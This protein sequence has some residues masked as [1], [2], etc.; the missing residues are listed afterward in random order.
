MNAQDLADMAWEL[1]TGMNDALSQPVEPLRWVPCEECGGMGYYHIRTG[2]RRC[3]GQGGSY[4]PVLVEKT[5]GEC[6]DGFV[7]VDEG[8]TRWALG[9]LVH[10]YDEG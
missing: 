5:C 2:E 1:G 9:T 3:P 7:Q 4:E 8:D 10:P 6:E